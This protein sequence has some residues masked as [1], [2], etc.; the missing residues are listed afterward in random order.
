MA[1]SNSIS[2]ELVTFPAPVMDAVA[3]AN[4]AGAFVVASGTAAQVAD[5]IR[6]SG[7]NWAWVEGFHGAG[8][9]NFA[10]RLALALGWRHVELDAL[11]HGRAIES[12]RYADHIDSGKLGL[13]IGS[14]DARESIVVDGVCLQDVVGDLRPSDPP[15]RIYVARVSNPSRDSYLWHDGLELERGGPES[16]A[17]WLIRDQFRYHQEFKPHVDPDFVVLRVES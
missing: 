16:D 13:A 10:A 14:G 8:K 1:D 2:S 11:A 15:V 6:S 4:R 9:T 3:T 12:D 7:K 5:A 17:P